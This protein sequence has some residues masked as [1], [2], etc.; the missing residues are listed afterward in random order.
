MRGE[1]DS[2]GRVSSAIE[3]MMV[4]IRLAGYGATLGICIH[5]KNG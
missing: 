3:K 5:K 2:G 4:Q 1:A